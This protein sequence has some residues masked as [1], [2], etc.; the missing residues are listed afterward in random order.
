MFPIRETHDYL[1][2]AVGLKQLLLPVG[3]IKRF[4]SGYVWAI[5]S[6]SISR[7]SLS[8]FSK[9]TVPKIR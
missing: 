1:D 6:K 8:A 7:L 4:F 5:L 3:R 2:R 9:E